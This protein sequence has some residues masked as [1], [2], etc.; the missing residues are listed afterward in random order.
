MRGSEMIAFSPVA[1]AVSNILRLRAVVASPS[2]G[3]ITTVKPAAEICR[4]CSVVM[5]GSGGPHQKVIGKVFGGQLG[6]GGAAE[7]CMAHNNIK[8]KKPKL[9][10]CGK[11]FRGII[12]IMN[13]Q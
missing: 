5:N 10:T 2:H 3:G 12:V 7:I 1:R 9:E 4:Y 13:S 11:P 6:S 8:P